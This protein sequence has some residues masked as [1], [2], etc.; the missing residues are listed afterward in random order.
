VEK[1]KADPA[2]AAV[3]KRDHTR[4]A[5]E[6]YDAVADPHHLFNLATH[7]RHAATLKEMSATL[8]AWMTANG[9]K[10][11]ATEKGQPTPKEK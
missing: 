6:L 9:D 8:D 1:L 4:P 3:V 2:A 10:G 11:L 5:D 7:S